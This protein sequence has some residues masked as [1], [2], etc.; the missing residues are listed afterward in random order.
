MT[1]ISLSEVSIT[2]KVFSTNIWSCPILSPGI[3][4]Q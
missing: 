4:G 1:F 2:P 3:P